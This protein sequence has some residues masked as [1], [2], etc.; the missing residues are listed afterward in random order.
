MLPKR[1]SNIPSME[2]QNCTKYTPILIHAILNPPSGQPSTQPF[3]PPPSPHS[4]HK[5]SSP[6]P[7]DSTADHTSPGPRSHTQAVAAPQKPPD[8]SSPPESQRYIY[9]SPSYVALVSSACSEAI[10]IQRGE[11]AGIGSEVGG[12][13]CVCVGAPRRFRRGK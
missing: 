5:D 8:S 4:P 13:V 7:A 9:S 3:A 2:A 6:A 11:Q 12:E 10:R 1:Q